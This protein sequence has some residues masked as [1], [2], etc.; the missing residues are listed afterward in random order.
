MR[1]LRRERPAMP[2]TLDAVADAAHVAGAAATLSNPRKRTYCKGVAAAYL[3]EV[4]RDRRDQ[5][6]TT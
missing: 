2:V 4:E 5:L 1:Y 6:S 3:R